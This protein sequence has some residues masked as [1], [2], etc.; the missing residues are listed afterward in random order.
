MRSLNFPGPFRSLPALAALSS[1]FAAAAQAD[2]YSKV[3]EAPVV[4]VQPIVE[5]R[6]ERI[7][8]EH[9]RTERVRV[10][11]RG[12]NRSFTPAIL[13]AVI[14]GTAGSVLGDNSSKRDIITGAGAILGASVGHDMGKRRRQNDG[15]YVTEDICSTD[16]EI[17]ESEQ[18]S[19]YRVR[20]RF[21]GSIYE[22][23]TVRDPGATI[24][25]RM[26]LEPLS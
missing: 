23:R 7:P 5:V 11:E 16:Y 14:G 3:I 12:G 13:G 26:R 21:D 2:S 15:Y 18:V 9:C 6:T 8:V 10:V 25:V 24:T 17:R 20:Y 22:T 19:G 1:A 4:D